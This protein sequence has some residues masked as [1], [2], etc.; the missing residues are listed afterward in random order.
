MANTKTMPQP[1]AAQEQTND[2]FY[3]AANI[4]HML[5]RDE[6]PARK[7]TPASFT[8]DCLGRMLSVF[9]TEGGSDV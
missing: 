3:H 7:R 9:T 1:N 8:R 5:D 4:E 2:P 6:V